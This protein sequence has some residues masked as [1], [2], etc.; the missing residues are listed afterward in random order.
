MLLGVVSCVATFACAASP[1]PAQPPPPPPAAQPASV[2]AAESPAAQEPA[3]QPEAVADAPE[4]EAAA[5]E[6]PKPSADPPAAPEPEGTLIAKSG[7]LV[8]LRL[9]TAKQPE[10]GIRRTL[11]RHFSGKSGDKTPL[12]A[13]GGLLGGSVQIG[14]WLTVADVVVQKVEGDVVTVEIEQERSQMTLNG[15][16]VNHF[17]AGARIRLSPPSE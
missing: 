6:A 2:A 16:P 5:P 1:P 14:G 4:P 11:L 9:D 13:L 8:K 17:T 7:K 15:K 3:P 10:V 12:G